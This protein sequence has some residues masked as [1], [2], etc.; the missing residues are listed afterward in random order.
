MNSQVLVTDTFDHKRHC[1]SNSNLNDVYCE[2]STFCEQRYTEG[3]Y[4]DPI[5]SSYNSQRPPQ[6]VDPQQ[7]ES[8]NYSSSLFSDS[9]IQA[10]DDGTNESSQHV[11]SSAYNPAL[12]FP[13]PCQS[14]DYN[15]AD[16]IVY[17]LSPPVDLNISASKYV[18]HVNGLAV[19]RDIA[20]PNSEQPCYPVSQGVT[21]LN[22]IPSNRNCSV[23]Q[24]PYSSL[25]SDN[26]HNY[27]SVHVVPPS[28]SCGTM[29]N[30]ATVDGLRYDTGSQIN[31]RSIG[32]SQ[33]PFQSFGEHF[34]HHREN[35]LSYGY[36]AYSPNQTLL[37]TSYSQPVCF[38][39]EQ[40]THSS[41][42]PEP[43]EIYPDYQSNIYQGTYYTVPYERPVQHIW[44]EQLCSTQ[45]PQWTSQ[46]NSFGFKE[47]YDQVQIYSSNRPYSYEQYQHHA[48]DF[49]EN[50]QNDAQGLQS[51]SKTVQTF[52]KVYYL[53]PLFT[54][55]TVLSL[56]YC[57]P[58]V[59]HRSIVW[60]NILRSIYITHHACRSIITLR[61]W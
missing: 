42:Y 41:H 56:V 39:T 50:A 3:K 13:E 16:Y 8:A 38:F 11:P 43:Q 53:M 33:Q 44:Q 10:Y 19:H 28:D 31:C 58:F 20:F 26:T 30:S 32:S 35:Q 47:S 4:I 27:T 22:N 49:A 29:Y 60:R 59:C 18:D 14:Y 6:V 55:L 36:P 51:M 2:S 54:I 57:E 46:S 5:S 37:S 15:Q 52:E 48:F 23:Y 45:Q 1:Y 61:H 12:S 40:D 7:D 34:A 21:T 25:Q 9:I 24:A 17:E